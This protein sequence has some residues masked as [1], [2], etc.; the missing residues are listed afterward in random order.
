LDSVKEKNNAA[1][2]GNR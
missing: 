1:S 2:V